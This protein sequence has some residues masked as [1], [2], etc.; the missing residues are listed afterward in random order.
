MTEENLLSNFQRPKKKWKKVVIDWEQ[1]D[2]LCLM[3]ATI[4]EICSW[5]NV[6]DAELRRAVK[7]EKKKL[8]QVYWLEKAA[9]GTIS[10]RRA[11][12]KA[13]LDGNVVM[14][15]WLGKQYLGQRETNEDNRNLESQKLEFKFV[16]T[17]EQNLM[18]LPDSPSSGQLSASQ[19]KLLDAE[20]KLDSEE[21][22]LARNEN[23]Q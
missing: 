12:W 17:D 7:K 10:L 6:Q 16:L 21:V 3:Q 8:L 11:Q 18:S 4:P 2:K 5:F 9:M 15:I 1:F 22:C 19:G 13:A 14:M 20:D 23:S